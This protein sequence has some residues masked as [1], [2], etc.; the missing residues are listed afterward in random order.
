MPSEIIVPV[1]GESVVEA[2][3]ARW[4]KKEGE[5]VSL[6]EPLVELETEKVNQEIAAG[7][8]GV[9]QK[10]IHREGATVKIGDALG[11][12]GAGDGAAAAAAPAEGAPASPNGGPP[13][14]TSVPAAPEAGQPVLAAESGPAAEAPLP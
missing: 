2:T 10:I 8:S 11:V 6:G 12:I 5:P 1:M 9:L 3:I 14:K 7:D 4:L 13:P